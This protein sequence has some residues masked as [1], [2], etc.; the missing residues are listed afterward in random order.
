MA[1]ILNPD[2][3]LSGK[4]NDPHVV[5]R[6]KYYLSKIEGNVGA[7]T[8]SRGFNFALESVSNYIGKRDSLKKG[9]S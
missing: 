2:L 7:Y 6:V 4:I 3:V 9:P 5:E 8:P 1:A